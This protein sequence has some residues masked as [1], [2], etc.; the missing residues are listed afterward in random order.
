M[1]FIKKFFEFIKNLFIKD[2]SIGKNKKVEINKENEK[3]K[4]ILSEIEVGDI[5]WAKRYNNTKEKMKIPKSHREGPFV[6]I[7]KTDEGL[8]CSKGSSV[9]NEA[10]FNNYYK[11]DSK[12]YNLFKTTYFKTKNLRIINEKTFIKKTD[13][14]LKEDEENLFKQI[15]KEGTNNYII[16]NQRKFFEL[17]FYIG[18]IINYNKINYI[19]TDIKDNKLGCVP[20]NQ[21][22]YILNFENFKKLDYSKIIYLDN[23]EAK[24]YISTV[25]IDVLSYVLK[26]QKEYLDNIKNQKV[27][28]RGSIILKNNKYYYVY[29]EESQ[30]WLIFE[31]KEDNICDFS[32]IILNNKKYYTKYKDTRI[33]KQDE[34]ETLFLV[35]E[36]EKD[37][38]QA[39]RR[40]YKKTR[41]NII[42]NVGNIIENNKDQRFIVIGIASN[43]YTCLSID[44]LK[45]GIYKK[46]TLLKSEVEPTEDK[47]I[48]GIKWLEK[49]IEFSLKHIT[50]EGIIENIVEY[51]KSYLN[52]LENKNILN[53]GSVFFKDEKNYYIYGEEGQDWLVFEI[54]Q[55]YIPDYDEI[56]INNTIFYT[57]YNSSKINKKEQLFSDCFANEKEIDTIKMKKKSFSKTKNNSLKY[58]KI[59]IGTV[60]KTKTKPEEQFVVV[61][62]YSNLVN[63]V[64]INDLNSKT[65]Y[66]NINSIEIIR[67][68]DKEE[69]KKLKFTIENKT[70][71]L[72]LKK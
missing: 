17:P 71:T 18:D 54:S 8:I 29:G 47:T 41:G 60:I 3:L 11:L 6:V 46:I 10:N 39:R 27:T 56:I 33:N 21:L 7:T 13:K 38:M 35:T 69:L 24:K 19:I 55:K 32:E 61:G 68:L 64:N 70:K 15:K 51:Q 5:I 9:Y 49:N 63:C 20:I 43:S 23:N 48:N 65:Y 30:E 28:Q 22:N 2:K 57:E 36:N 53:R 14:L 67:N 25:D 59:P 45:K 42:F 12:L 26:K 31:I 44:D 52:K 66:F 4:Q 40:S 16:N 62:Q 1:K 34:F 50:K 37:Y 72:K 58:K